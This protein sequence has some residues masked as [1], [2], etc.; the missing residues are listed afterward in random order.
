MAILE[1]FHKMRFIDRTNSFIR[2]F[3][4]KIWQMHFMFCLLS[5]EKQNDIIL[6]NKEIGVEKMINF[7]C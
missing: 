7:S 4:R 1:G 3:N 2:K 5:F 6:T